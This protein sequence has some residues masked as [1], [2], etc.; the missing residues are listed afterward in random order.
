MESPVEE[1]QSLVSKRIE[2][3][4]KLLQDRN[5]DPERGETLLTDDG[6]AAYR[7]F[8][9]NDSK[10]VLVSANTFEFEEIPFEQI[11]GCEIQN[12]GIKTNA[13]ERALTGAGI[14]GGL[15]FFA[16]LA[17]LFAVRGGLSAPIFISALI[18]VTFMSALLGA[19]TRKEIILNHRIVFLLNDP[20]TAFRSMTILPKA[21][22]V[23]SDDYRAVMRFAQ[24]V[25][26]S[27]LSIVNRR[28]GNC[29]NHKGTSSPA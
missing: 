11:A 9:D 7:F 4:N 16:L 6:K 18:S 23:G 26:L 27:V 13:A 28:K 14:G 21:E 17:A 1:L 22:A 12:N 3:Q 29:N 19:V 24:N 5:I 15:A 20:E 25:R 2:K 10:S 8:V